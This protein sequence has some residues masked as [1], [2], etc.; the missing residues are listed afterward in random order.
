[1]YETIMK[2]KNKKYISAE[3]IFTI[4][5]LMTFKNFYENQKKYNL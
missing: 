2:G 3:N 5:V 1:M 4:F